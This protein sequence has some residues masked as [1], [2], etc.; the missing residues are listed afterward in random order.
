KRLQQV[1]HYFHPWAIGN[2]RAS[3]TILFAMAGLF[4][5]MLGHLSKLRRDGGQKSGVMKP[6]L[7]RA[8]VNA[9]V[10]YKGSGGGLRVYL[11][12]VIDT[13]ACLTA[14]QLLGF[15]VEQIWHN[16]HPHRETGRCSTK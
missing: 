16:F 7:K 5:W 8:P 11:I 12:H 10:Y 13:S 3:L 6:T 4:G 14:R 9:T 2:S 15:G 1:R